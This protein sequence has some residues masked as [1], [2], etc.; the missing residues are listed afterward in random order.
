MIDE[1][2][3][4]ADVGL[5]AT[6]HIFNAFGGGVY[7]AN[8]RY[9]Y[10]AGDNRK[11]FYIIYWGLPQ[12]ACIELITRDWMGSGIGLESIL[13][14]NTNDIWNYW[15][16]AKACVEDPDGV[17]YDNELFIFC[18]KGKDYPLPVPLDLATDACN[19]SSNA[20][21]IAFNFK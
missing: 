19:C 16:G 4:I 10:Q 12:E 18:P 21:S 14:N 20:C 1:N 11:Y 6:H 15:E 13:T 3:S 7:I 8:D 9:A 2:N 5:G 17:A